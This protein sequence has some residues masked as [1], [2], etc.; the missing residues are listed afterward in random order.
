MLKT[1]N[2]IILKYQLE[3][4]LQCTFQK[5][6]ILGTKAG[7]NIEFISWFL[8]ADASISRQVIYK[9]FPFGPIPIAR[10]RNIVSVKKMLKFSLGINKNESSF[11]KTVNILCNKFISNTQQKGIEILQFNSLNWTEGQP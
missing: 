1:L 2:H 8:F 4:S 10:F 9:F 5:Q 11:L 3:Y 6:Y 7:R